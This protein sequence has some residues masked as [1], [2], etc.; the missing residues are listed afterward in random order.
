MYDMVDERDEV[1]RID[2]LVGNGW[3]EINIHEQDDF[4]EE[5]S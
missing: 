4:S 1:N 2:E 5:K 3:W